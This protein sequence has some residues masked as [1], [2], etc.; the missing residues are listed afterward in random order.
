MSAAQDVTA[1]FSLSSCSPRPQVV[2]SVTQSAAGRFLAT[3]SSTGANNVLQSIQFGSA[4][5]ALIDTGSQTG[6]SGNFSV[7]L[8][9]GTQQATFYMRRATQ[10][11]AITVPLVATDNCGSWST[12][13]GAGASAP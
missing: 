12:F 6:L 10:G 1:T 13:V 2:V 3:L 4:T 5:N 11:A 9:P 8:A 7:A